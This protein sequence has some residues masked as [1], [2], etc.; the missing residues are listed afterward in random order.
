MW[1]PSNQDIMS[2][3]E[4]LRKDTLKSGHLAWNQDTLLC[5]NAK[6]FHPWN[7]DTLLIRT[8]FLGPESVHIWGFHCSSGK[9]IWLNLNIEAKGSSTHFCFISTKRA[10]LHDH[11]IVVC[12]FKRVHT[13]ATSLSRAGVIFDDGILDPNS[14]VAR[15]QGGHGGSG[16]CDPTIELNGDGSTSELSRVAWEITIPHENLVSKCG[17]EGNEK[18]PSMAPGDVRPWT[19][20]C[21]RTVGGIHTGMVVP[22]HA[23]S[24]PSLR[25]RSTDKEES[26]PSTCYEAEF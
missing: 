1:T 15:A 11:L 26:Q 10:P 7:Q 22:E 2:T 5:P 3:M 25:V 20:F 6:L 21:I 24:D 12:G 16:V 19:F 8:R 23:V 18:S 13:N 17:L 4:P 9:G 14:V